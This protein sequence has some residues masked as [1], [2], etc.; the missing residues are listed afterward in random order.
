MEK[1]HTG[2]E[3]TV[4]KYNQFTYEP[5]TQFVWIIHYSYNSTKKDKTKKYIFE[6]DD[7]GKLKVKNP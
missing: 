3:L 2:K 1:A 4:I 6:A 5:G 7:K